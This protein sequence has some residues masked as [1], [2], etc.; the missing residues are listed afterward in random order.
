MFLLIQPLC[1]SLRKRLR[2]K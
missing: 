2:K 1:K